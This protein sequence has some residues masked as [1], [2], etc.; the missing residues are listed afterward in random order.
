V[1]WGCRHVGGGLEGDAGRTSPFGVALSILDQADFV[2]AV[3]LTLAP[4]W[5]MSPLQALVVFVSAVIGHSM[6]N[7]LGDAVGARKTWT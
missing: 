7:V 5:L 2:P 3:W 4:L 1:A 6:I